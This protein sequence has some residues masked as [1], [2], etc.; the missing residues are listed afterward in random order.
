MQS[1]ISIIE[2]MPQDELCLTGRLY[3][4][5]LSLAIDGLSL[6][7]ETLQAEKDDFDAL[8]ELAAEVDLRSRELKRRQDEADR[9]D[10]LHKL[11]SIPG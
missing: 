8:H 3:S 1:A 7:C 6:R 4:R 5:A 9:L 10:H 11:N 2:K